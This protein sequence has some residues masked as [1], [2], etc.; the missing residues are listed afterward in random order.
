MATPMA[1]QKGHVSGKRKPNA[2]ETVCRRSNRGSAMHNQLM[3]AYNTSS[4]SANADMLI[5]NGKIAFMSQ[6]H[7][8]SGT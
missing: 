5:P 8:D 1:P 7:F 6:D 2:A 4:H 3:H